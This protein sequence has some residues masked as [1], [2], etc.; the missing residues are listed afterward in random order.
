MCLVFDHEVSGL[1]LGYSP[2]SLCGWHGS[3]R[4]SCL[5]L[6]ATT[7]RSPALHCIP[8]LLLC[9]AMVTES[10]GM[11]AP[12]SCHKI[13]AVTFVILALKWVKEHAFCDWVRDPPPD[14]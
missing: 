7:G 14:P 1:G 4:H 10:Q 5:I 11:A 9:Q 13:R 8:Q 12:R 6:L 3:T 2:K